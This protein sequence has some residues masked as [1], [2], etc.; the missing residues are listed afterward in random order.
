MRAGMVLP[1]M[2][3]LLLA[4][5]VVVA[6]IHRQKVQ[7]WLEPVATVLLVVMVVI[8]RMAWSGGNTIYHEARHLS[9]R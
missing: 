9:T 7:Y 6:V 1:D 8:L 4:P 2:S 3:L 5:L